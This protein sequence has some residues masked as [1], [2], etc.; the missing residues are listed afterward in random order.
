MQRCYDKKSQEKQISYKNTIVCEEWHNF[1]NFAEWM[2]NNY[3]PETMKGW[4]LDKDILIK[5]N[6]I[7]S[8]ET[9][10]FVPKEINTL[11]LKSYKKRGELPI[12][13]RALP[14]GRYQARTANKVYGTFDTP[15]EAIQA[16]KTAKEKHIKEVADKWR[17]KITDQVYQAMYNYKVEIID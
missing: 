3:N 2:E 14:S 5:G 17:G 6:K 4:Q 9:C 11:I 12:G 15:E 7:Y 1:Q 13:V 10:S 16:Y 8:P